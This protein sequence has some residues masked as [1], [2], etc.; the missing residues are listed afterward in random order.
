MEGPVRNV[1][2]AAQFDLV[3]SERSLGLPAGGELGDQSEA[4]PVVSWNKLLQIAED[5]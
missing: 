1:T 5:L 4:I 3:L 2:T